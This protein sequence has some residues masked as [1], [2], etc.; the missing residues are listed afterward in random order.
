MLASGMGWEGSDGSTGD[1]GPLEVDRDVGGSD[2]WVNN[3]LGPGFREV[4]NKKPP[5]IASP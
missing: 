5:L 3:D 1:D 4:S 2:S